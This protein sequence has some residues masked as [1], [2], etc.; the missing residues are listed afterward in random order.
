LFPGGGICEWERVQAAQPRKTTTTAN[1]RQV[2]I[3]FP[4]TSTSN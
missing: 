3:Y 1:R 2:L 4:T